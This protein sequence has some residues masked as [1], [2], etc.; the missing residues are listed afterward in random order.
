MNHVAARIALLFSLLFVQGFAH[1]QY[2]QPAGIG[3]GGVPYCTGPLGPGPCDQVRRFLM[4]QQQP[5]FT[6]MMPASPGPGVPVGHPA[7]AP[8]GFTNAAVMPLQVVGNVPGVGPI[9]AGPLGPGPC[10]AVQQYLANLR[11]TLPGTPPA[12]AVQTRLL[13]I[14][15][16]VGP[17][18]ASPQGPAPCALVQQ[19]LQDQFAGSVANLGQ[20][21]Q[22]AGMSAQT[23]GITCAQRAG[24][25]VNAFSACSGM[26]VVLPAEKQAVLDCAV[27]SNDTPA[28]ANC[29]APYL[30]IHLS[31]DQQLAIACA[32]KS[33][34]DES[35][36][37]ACGADAILNRTLT[38]DEKALVNCAATSDD[39]DAFAGC[40]ARSMFG[41]HA[42]KEAQVAVQCAAQSDG[43]GTQ[44]AACAGANMIGLQLNPEQQI[45]VQ[46]VVST[47]GQ[48][49]AAAGCMASRLTARELL[50]CATHGFG[51]ADGCFGDNND[52]VG[53]NGWTARTLGSIA[54]GP[55]S[56]IRNPSQIWG[57]DNSF[58][59]NPGQVFGGPNSFVRDPSKIFGGPNS[60]FN[61]PGQLAPQPIN[62]GKI[63]GKRIC[64][65]W[66]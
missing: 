50:K 3:L 15:A 35:E 24:L 1:A 2:L 61:N 18:C 34:G 66:C 19:Q 65:P 21:I 59:R 60:I 58:V 12:P 39:T 22:S 32:S 29:A 4:G 9:C 7:A 48:P 23:L 42:P 20:A 10:V 27:S 53:K 43:N 55:N 56:V 11:P 47:G 63:G 14:V 36:F 30:G 26:Q 13:S 64:L 44:F 40:A 41:A 38:D 28:F 16:G 17:V 49:Y 6:A 31:S 46:C 5:A 33:N 51:G 52:L 54:G 8:P 25:D 62:V 45:A 57:G 37:I